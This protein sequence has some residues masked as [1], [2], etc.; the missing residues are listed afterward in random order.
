MKLSE[1]L[2][3]QPLVR[4]IPDAR[5]EIRKSLIASGK[6]LVVIDDDP[7]GMQTI[8]GVSVFMNWSV[9]VLRKAIA[10][11]APVFFVSTNSRSLS[12]K[13]TQGLSFEVG[14]NLRE[15]VRLEGAEI[16]LASRSDST[17]RGHFPYEV[18]AL[19]SGLGLELDGI[20]VAPA[21]FEAGRYTIDDIHWAEQDR[22]LVP[23]HQTEFARDPVFG[24]KNSNLK[25]WVAEKMNNKVGVEDVRSISLRLLREGGPEAVAGKLLEASDRV[26]IIVNAT[27]YEDL[28]IVALGILSAE[29][30]GKKFAYRCAASFIKARGGFEDKPLLTHQ[31]LA[32]GSGP[33][34]I[35]AG[36]YVEKTSRQLTQLLDSG[37]AEGIELRVQ[38]LQRQESRKSEIQSVSK[39][40]NQ[41]LAAGVTTVLYTSR[42]L[43]VSSN[44]NFQE[45]GN[46]IMQSL[47]EVV[48]RIKIRPGYLVAKG[49]S[50]SIEVARTALNVQEAFAIGQIIGGVPVW[51]LGAEAP[52]PEIPYVVFP[53]NVG[54]DS[55][56]LRVITILRGA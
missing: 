15:A 16:L 4:H 46:T 2:A 51:R 20:I 53:G 55:A 50:T 29:K 42:K 24:F 1:L 39:I 27:C 3:H 6:R 17:L 31:D 33:G 54:D 35:V 47:C 28:E 32:T 7:T 48:R 44:R 37:L 18:D 52:W 36:S 19:T 10:S 41:K 38:E 5:E 40:M 13:E 8:H 56:L 30:K 34:L 26:P 12:A 49:G 25:A 45:M 21:F 43:R 23:V 22:E 9:D 11:G 14:R